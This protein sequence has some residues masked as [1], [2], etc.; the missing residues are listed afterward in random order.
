MESH[1]GCIIENGET[2]NVRL[3]WSELQ[4]HWANA[5]A[6]N[7]LFNFLCSPNRIGIAEK[8][9]AIFMHK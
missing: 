2:I 6:I 5:S 3:K 7:Q 9:R 1:I 8:R 4:S